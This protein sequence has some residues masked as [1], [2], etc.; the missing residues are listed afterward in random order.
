MLS[1]IA[2]KKGCAYMIPDN[3]RKLR[4]KNHMSQDELAEKLGVSRQS[5]SLWENG[6][7]QPTIENIIA[8][9]KVFDVSSDE[10]LM[11]TD[12]AGNAHAAEPTAVPTTQPTIQPI[13]QPT[14]YAPAEPAP[15]EKKSAPVWP[16]ILVALALLVICAALYYEL[17]L[18]EN[19]SLWG[20]TSSAPADISASS[21]GAAISQGGQS[22]SGQQGSSGQQGGGTVQKKDIFEE[23]KKFAIENGHLN[24]DYT[25]YQQSAGKYGGRDNEYFS[26]SYWGDSDMVEFCLHCPLSETFSINFYIRMRG[27]YNGKY[28]YCTSRYYR[29]TGKSYRSAYGYIDPAVFSRNY[30]LSCSE[31]NGPTDGQ[32]DFMEESRV[33]ICD[34]ID[35]IGAFV[36]TENTGLNFSDFDFVNFG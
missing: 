22:G 26:V 17:V 2:F 21:T 5:V 31:Y 10:I 14:V 29:D 25:I 35:L 30:P 9:A 15:Q 1:F 3:I 23:C 36:R 8:L 13:I 20:G 33:G 32:D 7:T 19:G 27:G 6:Q 28:E 16:I 34:L 4:K 24:G 12:A 18:K 11:G